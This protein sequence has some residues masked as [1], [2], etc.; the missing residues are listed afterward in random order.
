MRTLHCGRDSRQGTRVAYRVGEEMIREAGC[1]ARARCWAHLEVAYRVDQ[2]HDEYLMTATEGGPF[3]EKIGLV[4]QSFFNHSRHAGSCARTHSGSHGVV[5]SFHIPEQA[6]VASARVVCVVTT[7]VD[8]IASSNC[9]FAPEE[10]FRGHRVPACCPL[11]WVT[12]KGD[13][14]LYVYAR[15]AYHARHDAWVDSA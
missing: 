12:T 10:I 4:A 14:L 7:R 15:R 8:S 3:F 6:P 11:R 13:E 1:R 9:V 2:S 5:C